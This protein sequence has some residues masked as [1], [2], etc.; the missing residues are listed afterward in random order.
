MKPR[1]PHTTFHGRKAQA[2]ENDDV[3]VVVTVEGGHLAGFIDK[4]TGANPLWIPHWP[5]IEP[6]AY[7]RANDATYG[8][9]ADGKLLAGIFGHNLCLD[10]FGGPSAAETAAGITTHGESSVALYSI[11]R[12]EAALTCSVMLPSA[13]LHFERILRLNGRVLAIRE[14]VEN[15]APTDRPIAWTQHV[16]L[17]APFLEKGRTQFRASATRSKTIESDFSGGKTYM[18]TNAELDWPHCPRLDGG[19]EDLRVY[20]SEPVSAGYT[21]HLMNPERDQAF[22]TAWSPSSRLLFGYVWKQS[23][24]PWLGIWEENYSRAETPWNGKEL[25]RGMEFGVSPFP[26]SR[27]AMIERGSLFGVPGYRWLEAKSKVTVEYCA[28]LMPADSIPE[29]VIREESGVR[30]VA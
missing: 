29:S 17:G 30:F 6:S 15:Q 21:A 1:M 5:S 3:R 11:H 2:I 18:K 10:L 13:H 25:T 26:E 22:F 20:T 9:V 19:F 12:D 7:A 23:D 8:G 27:R 24:F 4:R 14:T 16:T 28:F